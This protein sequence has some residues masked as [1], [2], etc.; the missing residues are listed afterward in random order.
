MV[1]PTNTL[2]FTV[3]REQ[4]PPKTNDYRKQRRTTNDRPY[5]VSFS[6]LHS[7][8]CILHFLISPLQT[9]KEYAIIIGKTTQFNRR[10][11]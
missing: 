3:G 2:T 9:P 6:T 1:A 7:A 4:A 10:L 11:L 8:L 5:D